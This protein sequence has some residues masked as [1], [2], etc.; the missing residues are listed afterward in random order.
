VPDDPASIIPTTVTKPWL[1]RAET[2]VS[3]AAYRVAF[4]LV[5]FLNPGHSY[6]EIRDGQMR[7][8]TPSAPVVLPDGTD[9]E[10]AL[11][12]ARREAER[13]EGRRAIIDDKSK[14][15]LTVS[16]LLLAANSALLPFLPIR[17]IGFIP[18]CFVLA[19]IFL[20]LMYFRT[21]RTECV[22]PTKVDWAD[23]AKAQLDIARVEFE[24]ARKMGPQNDLR[25][26]VH[27]AA[28]RA[29]ILALASV[30]PVLLTVAFV[31]PDDALV[32][33]IE[34]D[35]KVRAL[36][37]GPMGVAGPVGPVGPQGLPGP[38]GP[39]GAQGPTGPMGP[40]GLRGADGP[41]GPPGP[42]GKSGGE[43]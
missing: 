1:E 9:A 22:D 10:L 42:P 26:G 3:D 25:V 14:V 33:R 20:T 16:T 39:A 30:V 7:H 29:L 37:Q 19:A 41:T 36:L 11:D 27:K 13:E 24:C 23:K 17:W 15:M 38:T 6:D 28:R 34:T 12:E 8:T 5:Y 2:W 40:P 35:A 31:T 32:K 43:Q 21:Y 4:W 18:I